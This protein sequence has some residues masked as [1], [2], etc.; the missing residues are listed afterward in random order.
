MKKTIKLLLIAVGV[1]LVG[2]IAFP[3]LCD[4]EN[5]AWGHVKKECDCLGIKIDN[6]CKTPNG[7]SCPDAGGGNV[8]VGI[9]TD[10]R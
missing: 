5:F 10:R 7:Q 9:V 3:K 2:Y 6:S 8:C 1:I 4:Y